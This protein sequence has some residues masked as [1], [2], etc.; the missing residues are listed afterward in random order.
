MTV[1]ETLQIPGITDAGKLACIARSRKLSQY[2][3][4]VEDALAGRCPFC[5]PD[6]ER[7]PIIVEGAD[8]VA[9]ACNPPEKHTAY[10]FLIVPR[11]HITGTNE[12]AG[13]DIAEM[14]ALKD[15]LQEQFGFKSAGVQIRD[16]NATL[17]AGTIE[18][19]HMHIM[20][21]DGKGRLESPFFKGPENE[22]ASLD[23]AI[24][25]E[26]LRQG[27]TI[28]PAEQEIVKGRLD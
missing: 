4:M 13:G 21:P 27:K 6:P 23:R 25:F 3:G 17:L 18:H 14:F 11:R 16:G 26:K 22:A 9:W 5:T 7:N 19:L 20:V 24:V 1:P 2:T 28:S 12:L 15:R 10:H 8:C